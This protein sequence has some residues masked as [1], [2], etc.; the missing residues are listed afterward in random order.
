M[1]APD[2]AFDALR[3]DLETAL[4]K[5]PAIVMRHENINPHPKPRLEADE[6]RI[7]EVEGYLRNGERMLQL[8]RKRLIDVDAVYRKR[9]GELVNK[10]SDELSK[11]D[12]E[13]E[14]DVLGIRR[15]IARLEAMRDG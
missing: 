7:G 14:A 9:R 11:L 1:N 5:E 13:H 8:A 6:L 2:T 3:Q 12:H 4:D 10:L 15:I